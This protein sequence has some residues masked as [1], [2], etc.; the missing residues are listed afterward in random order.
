M[1]KTPRHTD[2]ID[3][4]MVNE[5]MATVAAHTKPEKTLAFT[6]S[7]YVQDELFQP[8]VTRNVEGSLR[9]AHTFNR[10]YLQAQLHELKDWADNGEKYGYS[11]QGI[12]E[13]LADETRS[14]TTIT[15]DDYAT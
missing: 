5:T 11:K 14:S 12:G 9:V 7:K 2:T 10:H 8:D 1:G 6:A 15:F 13:Y 4:A 3:Q